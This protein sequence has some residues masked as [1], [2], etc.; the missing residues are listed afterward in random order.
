[1]VP[2]SAQ[3]VTGNGALLAAPPLL[4]PAGASPPPG[5]INGIGSGF[6]EQPNRNG[7]IRGAGADGYGVGRNPALHG[8]HGSGT[9]M[10]PKPVGQGE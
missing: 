8:G 1:M 9:G 5:M 6:G 4:P 2:A 3:K 7:T 10:V